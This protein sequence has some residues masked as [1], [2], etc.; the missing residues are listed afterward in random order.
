MPAQEVAALQAASAAAS[1][2]GGCGSGKANATAQTGAAV[3]MKGAAKA[4][5]HS[6]AES[7]H[8]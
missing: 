5:L 6:A 7:C 2:G 8:P 1:A 3:W 4:P